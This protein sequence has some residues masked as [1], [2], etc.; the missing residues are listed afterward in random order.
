MNLVMNIKKWRLF[1]DSLKTSW[2]LGPI[3]NGNNFPSVPLV[4][5]L[6]WRKHENPVKNS[7]SKVLLEDMQQPKNQH[8]DGFAAGLH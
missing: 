2:R 5:Q 4:Q 8:L 7:V 6:K 3:H 1:I